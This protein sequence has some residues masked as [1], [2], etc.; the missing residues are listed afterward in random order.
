MGTK[1][2]KQKSHNLNILYNYPLGI[3]SEMGKMTA[4]LMFQLLSTF[5]KEI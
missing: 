4:D 3:P 2:I 5:R 1:K